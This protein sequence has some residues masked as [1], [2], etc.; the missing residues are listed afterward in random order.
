MKTIGRTELNPQNK[1]YFQVQKE[2][3]KQSM[4]R[5]NK[6]HM[7]VIPKSQMNLIKKNLSAQSGQFQT[8]KKILG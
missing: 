2:H 6:S 8:R 5:F 4:P 1:V 3:Q 7:K